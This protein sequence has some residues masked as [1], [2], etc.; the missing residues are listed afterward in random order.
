MK[1]LLIGAGA[2]H[3]RRI[4]VDGVEKWD[5]LVTLDINPDHKPDVIHDLEE[6]PYPFEDNEFDEV[7]AYEVLEHTGQQGDWRFFFAQFSELWRVLKPNGALAVSVPHWA[8][9][10]AWGD[11]SHKRIINEGTVVFLNQDEYAKQVGKTSMSDFR[12]VY[13]GNFKMDMATVQ[14]VEDDP[15]FFFVLRARKDAGGGQ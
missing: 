11:P 2:K 4:F 1:S 5:E 12:W 9:R 15:Y 8:G 7:H 14:K 10:W 6:L 3:D 13:K